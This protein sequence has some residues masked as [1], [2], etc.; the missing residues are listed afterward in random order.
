LNDTQGK[1][2]S[3]A[4]YKGRYVLLDFWAS[5]CGPCRASFPELINTYNKYKDKKFQILG[6]SLDDKKELWLKAIETDKLPWDQVSDLK[7]AS[8]EVA[9]LYNVTQI[10]Q[11]LLIDP[12]GVIVGRNLVGKSL[13]DKLLELYK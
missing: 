1:P 3:L 6:V 8:S 4:S 10:P 7:G 13:E 12:N 11:N 5:W 9:K 2:V